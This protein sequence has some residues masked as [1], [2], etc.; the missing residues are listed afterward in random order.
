VLAYRAVDARAFVIPHAGSLKST[1]SLH[2][3]PVDIGRRLDTVTHR[4]LNNVRV[5]LQPYTTAG[6]VELPGLTLLAAARRSS[7]LG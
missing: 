4:H 2:R 6:G 7:G 1:A 5:T 3:I